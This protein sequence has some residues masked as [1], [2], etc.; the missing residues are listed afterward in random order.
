MNTTNNRQ[1][2]QHVPSLMSKNFPNNGNNFN[3]L[4]SSFPQ[5][6]PFIH[7]HQPHTPYSTYPKSAGPNDDNVKPKHI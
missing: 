4:P 3:N 1:Q 5:R 2:T 7:Q 6:Q